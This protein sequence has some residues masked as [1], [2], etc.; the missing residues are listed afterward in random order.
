MITRNNYE[1]FFLLYVDNELSPADRQAVERFVE[2]H[3]DLKEEWELLLQCRIDPDKTSFPGRD[4]LL[5]Q[6][7]ADT[8]RIDI[9]NYESW[10]LSYVDD[11]LDGRDRQTVIDFIRQHP[12]KNIELQRIQRTVNIPDPA[13]VFPDK[14]SLYRTEEKRRIAWLPFARIAA[15][16][17][18]LGVVGWL[19]FHPFRKGTGPSLANTQAP[20][21]S[22]PSPGTPTPVTSTPDDRAVHP[23]VKNPTTPVTPRPADP[24]Y[25]SKGGQQKTPADPMSDEG[26]N[27]EPNDP[28]PVL[29]KVDLPTPEKTAGA[30]PARHLAVVELKATTRTT[31]I[32][33]V[34]TTTSDLAQNTGN[35]HTSFATQAL[36]EHAG[37]Q[38]EELQEETAS[39]RKNKLRG[40][41]RRV[42]RTLEKP[43]GR[44]DDENK[45]VIIGGFQF[46]LK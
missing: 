34:M 29:A 42:T 17:L 30:D 33:V 8:S 35:V 13:I 18:V 16:A 10:F 38:D 25:L 44:E 37:D 32:P 45:K 12:E 22:A 15:A 11:E 19:I 2:E 4:L 20:T 21:V 27:K 9:Y 41:L 31:T 36:L 24:L 5:K 40:I 1:E 6:G 43:T 39:P 26:K 23:L 46:A 7:T 28:A 14:E 3:P